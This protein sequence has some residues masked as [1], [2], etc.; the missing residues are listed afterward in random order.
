MSLTR[1]LCLLFLV[2]A[3]ACQNTAEEEPPKTERPN[4]LFIMTDD[5]ARKAISSYGSD[6]IETPN[7]DRIAQEGIRFTNSFVTNSI[8]APSRA[9]LLTGKYS[10]LNGLRDNRDHFDGTQMNFAKLLQQAGYATSV[11]GKWH[12]K[13]QPTGFDYWDVLIGQG[14]YYNPRM[15]RMGDTMTH[16]GYTTEIITDI[17]LD[18]LEK[19]DTTKPFCMLYHHKAPHRNWMPNLKDLPEFLQKEYPLPPTL[20]DDYAGREAAAAQD[21]EIADM[22]MSSDMK[23]LPEDYGEETGTG[24]GGASNFRAPR[25]WDNL[26]K[27]LTPEQRKVWDENY[28]PIRKAFRENPPTGRDLVIWKYQRYMQDYMGSVASV[29]E[30]IGRVLEYLDEQGLAENTIVVYTS[31]Q[32]FYL[33]EHGWYD[34]RFMYEESFSMPL[35]MRYPAGVQGGQV[36]D[37]LV[38]N[39]DFAP[40]F[41]DYAG[42]EAPKDM[43]G[44]SMRPI[45]E[46]D[47]GDS[48]RKSV[49]Y[50][51]Y[52]YPHGW[53]NVKRHEGVRDDRYKLI[54]FYHDIDDWELYDLATDSLEVNNLADDPAHQATKERLQKELMR[55]REFYQVPENDTSDMA[56]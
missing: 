46:G 34:K 11:I 15:V 17:A 3:V 29:D 31:D 50:H 2:A 13:T 37:E 10:H 22:Y 26:R 30:N 32:G 52:E 40:T 42:V 36:S 9:V 25:N 6:L 12:L 18:V 39:L 55:L 45:W 38:L 47:T 1:L 54:H 49:Y 24:G 44:A 14:N 43:Q 16:T 51:Y 41:L 27:L 8:C 48:W 7:I 56:N 20:F 19:R 4:I 53:H 35:V 33:G 28:D 23:L 21:M 5:H